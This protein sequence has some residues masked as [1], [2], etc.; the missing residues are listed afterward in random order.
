MKRIVKDPEERRT[1]I[2]AAAE[3]LF[4]SQGYAETTVD[5]IIQKV[6][7]AKVHFITTSIQG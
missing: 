2:L 7:V 3:K 1:E 6:G 5:A 4:K